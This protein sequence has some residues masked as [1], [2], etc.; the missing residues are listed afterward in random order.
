MSLV[1]CKLLLIKKQRRFGFGKLFPQK[2]KTSSQQKQR[3]APPQSTYAA[4]GMTDLITPTQDTT[5]TTTTLDAATFDVDESVAALVLHFVEDVRD[6]FALSSVSR[7]WRTVTNAAN[8]SSC[9]GQ[10]ANVRLLLTP[11]LA[12]ALTDR[13]VARLLE[14]AGPNLRSIEI[15]GAPATFI[16]QGLWCRMSQTRGEAVADGRTYWLFHFPQL[17]TLDLSR[18]EGVQSGHVLALLFNSDVHTRPRNERL[19]KLG[20]AGCSGVAA[21]DISQLDEFVQHRRLRQSPFHRFGAVQVA[22][23]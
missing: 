17:Q 22:F 13:R 21:Q 23:I 1:A 7:V 15:H 3:R 8:D 6:R 16:G 5:A 14:C 2:T 10:A 18:C 11:P 20:L 19:D 4:F 12:A 9:F